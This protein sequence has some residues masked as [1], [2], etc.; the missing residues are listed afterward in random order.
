MKKALLTFVFSFI[1]ISIYAQSNAV[2]QRIMHGVL[3]PDG[4]VAMTIT[5]DFKEETIKL[6]SVI[7][8]YKYQLLDTKTSEPV[9]TSSNRG[10][11]CTFDKSKISTGN[12]KL[13]VYTKNFIIT[14]K[15]AISTSSWLIKSN[16]SIAAV[17]D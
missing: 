12:Y 4:S 15:I 16:N 11:E 3:A 9:L 7:N 8:F 1:I 10:K 6:K 2:S 14:S 17:N 5:D 13:R